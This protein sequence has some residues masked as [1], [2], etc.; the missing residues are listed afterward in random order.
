MRR[1]ARERKGAHSPREKSDAE[2]SARGG[3]A[4]IGVGSETPREHE[5]RHREPTRQQ[6]PHPPRDPYAPPLRK[7][8]PE[9]R[10]EGKTRP[11]TEDLGSGSTTGLGSLR[12]RVHEARIEHGPGTSR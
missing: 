8:S 5:H 10:N 1:R 12:D 7:T 2:G 9:Q 11:V 3:R 6:N 4:K